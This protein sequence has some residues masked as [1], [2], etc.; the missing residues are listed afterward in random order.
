[1]NS[2]R[3]ELLNDPDMLSEALSVDGIAYPPEVT[4]HYGTAYLPA[5]REYEVREYYPKIAEYIRNQAWQEL[6]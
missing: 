1:M 2:E 6:G 4:S 5:Q 3:E